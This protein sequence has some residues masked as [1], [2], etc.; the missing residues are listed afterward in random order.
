MKK[1]IIVLFFSLSFS[2]FS[3]QIQLTPVLV[4]SAGGFQEAS[5]GSIS[6]SAGEAIVTTLDNGNFFLTQGFHQP[7]LVSELEVV[8]I[9]KSERCRGSRDGAAAIKVNGGFPPYTF[10]WSPITDFRDSVGTLE[11]GLYSVIVRDSYGKE[12]TVDFYIERELNTACLFHIYSGITPNG[13]SQND[14]WII[15][16]IE[17][18]PDNNVQIYNRW[19]DKVWEANAYNNNTVVWDGSNR[20]GNPLPDGTYFYIVTLMGDVFKGWV[21]LTR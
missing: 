12:A 5:W 17:N 18:F 7:N 4:G 1:G 6:F 16:G 13:D 20:R 11:S 19:G 14:T 8:V 10:N 9:T 21:E 2:A 3:Q 15:D